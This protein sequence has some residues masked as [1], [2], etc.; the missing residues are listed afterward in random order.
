MFFFLLRELAKRKSLTRALLN[1]ELRAHRLKGTVLDV[2]G[3]KHRDYLG[4]LQIEKDAKIQTADLLPREQ[5]A[6][7]L[8][9]ETDSLPY[10]DG[11]LD[12]IIVFNVL[13][14]IFNHQ[15]LTNEM[16]RVLKPGAPLL[17]FV[18]FL[19]NYH[20]DP[21]DYFRYTK[22]A[23]QRIF[24]H[25]QFEKI[26]IKTLGGGPFF[27]AFNTIALSIPRLVRLATFP[28]C[29]ALDMLFLRLRPHARERFPLGY[30]FVLER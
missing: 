25:A 24:A 26:T 30:F 3:G 16:R 6:K 2:G 27:V 11:S 4:F 1:A 23:L 5:G 15:F 12:Q 10:R 18:P 22:E 7:Q 8:D 28:V 17:G 19:I 14:H 29:Y 9:F 13:E 21:H 20:P